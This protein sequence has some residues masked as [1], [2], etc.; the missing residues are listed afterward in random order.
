VPTQTEQPNQPANAGAFDDLIAGNRS[1]A[2]VFDL[3]GLAPHAARGLAVI[4]CMDSRIEPL[5]MLGLKPGDAKI[6]RN[7]GARIT[8]DV[9]RT[10][11]LGVNLLGVERVLVVPH[12]NC[13][14]FGERDEIAAAVAQDGGPDVGDLDLLT[15][16]DQLATLRGDLKILRSSPL[17]P[18]IEVAGAL[19]DV[20]TGLL[21]PLVH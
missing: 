6:L 9:L 3:G 20:D 21:G 10:L 1:Y 11:T 2:D 4:L 16:T 18:G 17:L 7:G 8:S 13:G 19:Y 5:G 15:T 12:T 14:T